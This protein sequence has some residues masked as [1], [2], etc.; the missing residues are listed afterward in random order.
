MEASLIPGASRVTAV[1]GALEWE[2]LLRDGVDG[3]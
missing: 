1:E 2:R 3:F